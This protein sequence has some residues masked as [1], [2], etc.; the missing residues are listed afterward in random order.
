VKSSTLKKVQGV[1]IF[2]VFLALLLT[3]LHYYRGGKG[4]KASQDLRSQQSEFNK[5]N[6]LNKISFE[7]NSEDLQASLDRMNQLVSNYALHTDKR[8]IKGNY[9][10]FVFSLE[11]GRLNALRREL[12]KIG[13]IGSEV[14]AVDTSLVNTNAEIET[15]NLLSY[16]KDLSELDKIR[17]PSDAELRRKESLRAQIRRS[18]QK[19]D[20]LKRSDSYLVY[21]SVIPHGKRISAIRSVS[22]IGAYFLK[23]L[24]FMFV[25]AILVY[26][27]TRLLMYLLALMGFKGITGKG[28]MFSPYQYGGYSSYQGRYYSSRGYGRSSKR[29]VK[30]VYKDK[31]TTPREGEEKPEE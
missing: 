6:W 24:G 17:V 20:D 1:A 29:R 12:G 8:E 22:D 5:R 3:V 15:A 7:L 14:E 21:V 27:G 18:Q 23:T 11:K 2:L 30:R 26:Y 25:A 4:Q 10:V 31:V 28:G 13:T 19:L 16:E 9:G